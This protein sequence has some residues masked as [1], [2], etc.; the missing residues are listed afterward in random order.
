VKAFVLTANIEFNAEDIDDACRLLA[1]H[2]AS[3]CQ[4]DKESPLAFLGEIKLKPRDPQP[5]RLV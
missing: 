5:L 4:E 1:E 3:V 2:F